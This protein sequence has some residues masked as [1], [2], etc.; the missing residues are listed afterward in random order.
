MTPLSARLDTNPSRLRTGSRRRLAER[1]SA[2]RAPAGRA[3][4][5]RCSLRVADREGCPGQPRPIPCRGAAHQDQRAARHLHGRAPPSSSTGSQRRSPQILSD[6]ATRGTELR[7]MYESHPVRRRFTVAR[8]GSSIC[9][10]ISPPCRPTP[11]RRTR[12]LRRAAPTS[13]RGDDAASPRSRTPALDRDVFV[14][15]RAARRS[16]FRAS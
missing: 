9:C 6:Q 1:S 3:G 8:R 5:T 2:T 14:L 16:A 15:H 11:G 13:G 10:R 4:A 12:R 7:Q